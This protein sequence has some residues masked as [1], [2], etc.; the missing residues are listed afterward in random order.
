MLPPESLSMSLKSAWY[1]ISMSRG[2]TN[3]TLFFL[4]MLPGRITKNQTVPFERPRDL[5]ILYQADFND[6]VHELRGNIADA[7]K[8]A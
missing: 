8:A 2:L 3:G 6:I 5:E 1:W 7:R 4:V